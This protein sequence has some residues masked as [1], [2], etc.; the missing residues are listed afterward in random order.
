MMQ[1]NVDFGPRR[2]ALTGCIKCLIL[3]LFLLHSGVVEQAMARLTIARL[4][5]VLR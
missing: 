3:K 5:Q 1:E 4:F 2:S